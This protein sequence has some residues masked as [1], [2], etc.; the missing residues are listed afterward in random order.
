MLSDLVSQSDQYRFFTQ[1]YFSDQYRVGFVDNNTA[2]VVVPLNLTVRFDDGIKDRLCFSIANIR[3][4]S[5][6]DRAEDNSGH[7]K[8][9]CDRYRKAHIPH[10][11]ASQTR[12]RNTRPRQQYA[13]HSDGILQQYSQQGWICRAK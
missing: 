10:S 9:Q 11:I 13:D 5:H 7:A 6:I 2:K 3:Q 12:Q 8:H 1:F 4:Q